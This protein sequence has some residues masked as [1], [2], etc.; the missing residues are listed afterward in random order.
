MSPGLQHT[1]RTLFQGE[2]GKEGVEFNMAEPS[3]CVGSV[4]G[5]CERGLEE[6]RPK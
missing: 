3:E 2:R 4:D 5:L 1:L 6:A